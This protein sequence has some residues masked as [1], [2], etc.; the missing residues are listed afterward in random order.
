MQFE[1]N[2]SSHSSREVTP[3]VLLIHP[4]AQPLHHVVEL[5]KR[6]VADRQVALLVAARGDR[7]PDAEHAEQA[8]LDLQ[9]VVRFLG[10]R[11]RAAALLRR[12]LAGDQPLGLAHGEV[13]ADDLHRE[14]RRVR[15]VEQRAAVPGRE[16]AAVEQQLDRV[17]QV[18]QAERVGDVAPALAER[19]RELVLGAV[20]LLGEAAVAL[21]LLDRGEVLALD[22]LDQ[23][24]LERGRVRELLDQHRHLVEPRRLGRAP[25]PLA[26]DDLVAPRLARVGADDQRLDHAALPDR[27]DQRRHRLVLEGL[28]RL[29]RARREVGDRQR[30]RAPARAGALRGRRPLP[31]R[32]LVVLEQRLQPAAELQSGIFGHAASPC[33]R[34]RISPARRM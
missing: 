8:A 5:L 26:G 18:E 15:R 29:E 20:E 9:D 2:R 23:R 25:A 16:P 12:G 19:A 33:S 22:V 4:L 24:D 21:G 14:R 3:P 32:R 11:A 10:P 1:D 34:L 17:R 28:A 27:V 7:D 31:G 30:R 6:G 13:A